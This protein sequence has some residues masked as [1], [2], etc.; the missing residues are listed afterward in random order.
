MTIHP[1]DVLA[2]IPKVLKRLKDSAS[3]YV[4]VSRFNVADRTALSVLIER[5]E[6]ETFNSVLGWA[7]RFRAPDLTKPTCESCK[8]VRLVATVDGSRYVPSRDLQWVSHP[9][10][11]RER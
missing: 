2:R 6:V 5:G 9:S 4:R 11:H 10:C 3:K 1:P 7:Y 8:G